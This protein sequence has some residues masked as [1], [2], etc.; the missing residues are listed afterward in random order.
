MKTYV[1][2]KRVIKD[3]SIIFD[4]TVGAKDKMPKALAIA[5]KEMLRSIR[6]VNENFEMTENN[7]NDDENCVLYR[8]YQHENTTIEIRVN[9][10]PVEFS[11]VP[12]GEDDA[13]S[14]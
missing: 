1:I 10:Y 12:G 6:R 2:R 3:G 13:E 11:T 7:I 5:E 14:N 9:I 4:S 8:K